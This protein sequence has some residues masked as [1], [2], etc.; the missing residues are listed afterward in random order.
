MSKNYLMLY[1]HFGYV[2]LYENYEIKFKEYTYIYRNNFSI[3]SMPRK[4][5]PPVIRMLLPAKN[6]GISL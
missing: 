5:E 1:S 2:T 3:R 4:P 6:S